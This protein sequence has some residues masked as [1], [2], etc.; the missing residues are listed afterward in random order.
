MIFFYAEKRFFTLKALLS[1]S[2]ITVSASFLFSPSLQIA[3]ITGTEWSMITGIVLFLIL[4][5]N[6]IRELKPVYARYPSIF[7]F[8]PL[9]LLPLFPLIA[10]TE[11]LKSLLHRILQGGA[12][13]IS[14]FLAIPLIRTFEY[15]SHYLVSTL[16]LGITYT[17]YWYLGEF[18]DPW[19][20]HLTL[21]GGVA[22]GS[23][24]L[25]AL[26]NTLQVSYDRILT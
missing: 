16:L 15:S 6:L 19:A 12:V 3:G 5:A 14:L 20:W 8:L 4:L 11:I 23:W 10:E 7:T 21:A 22:G 24:S 18:I 2:L 9:I 25:N 1:L 13:V 17:L 26:I